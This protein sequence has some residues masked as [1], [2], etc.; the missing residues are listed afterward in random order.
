MTI[1]S[2]EIIL[3]CIADRREDEPETMKTQFIWRYFASFYFW[4]DL[5]STVSMLLDVTWFLDSLLEG[6]DSSNTS[7]PDNLGIFSKTSR[8]VR[9]GSRAGRIAR[10]TRLFRTER[11]FSLY[12]STKLNMMNVNLATLGDTVM[13]IET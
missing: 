13:M 6:D 10:I 9:I 12:R 3:Q 4:L 1:Y 7:I 2:L 11:M 8:G 5:L